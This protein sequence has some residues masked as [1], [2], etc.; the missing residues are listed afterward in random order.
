MSLPRLGTRG[1][2][3]VISY[4][5]RIFR[6]PTWKSGMWGGDTAIVTAVTPLPPHLGDKGHW[7]VPRKVGTGNCIPNIPPVTSR[8]W[9]LCPEKIQE[10]INRK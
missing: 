1:S 4:L 10:I 9:D 5:C 8:G 7:R 3:K 2:T 6:N